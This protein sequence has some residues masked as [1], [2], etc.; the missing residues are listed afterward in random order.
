MSRIA[1]CVTVLIASSAW[2]EHA[3]SPVNVAAPA[4]GDAGLLILAVGV[5]LAGSRMIR[6]YRK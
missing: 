3:A 2:A 4:L 5:G 6:K 1:A